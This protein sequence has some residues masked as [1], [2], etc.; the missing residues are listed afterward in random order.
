MV[1]IVMVMMHL[2]RTGM[3]LVFHVESKNGVHRR[4]AARY[5]NDRRWRFKLCFDGGAGARRGL[6]V[7]KVGLRKDNQ[8]RGANLI[9]E[10][11][12]NRTFMVKL[13]VSRTLRF[14]R[15]K[16]M[17]HA[18]IGERRPV[19]QRHDAVQHHL[20]LDIRPVERLNKRL[21]QR[22]AGCL[23]DDM[24]R[25]RLLCQQLLHAWQEII[26]DGAADASIGK[27]DDVIRAAAFGTTILEHRAIHANIAE[28]VDN[29]GQTLAV[30]LRDDVADQRG[31][32]GP[33]EPG[34]HGGGDARLCHGADLSKLGGVERPVEQKGAE[35]CDPAPKTDCRPA[36]QRC[37]YMAEKTAPSTISTI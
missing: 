5:R 13:F 33:K 20:V 2:R 26:G 11:L 18:A 31:F 14:Q 25:T 24:V 3:R 22:E 15:S 29:Q 9:R 35:P 21:R 37:H 36:G 28:F 16:V 6:L 4:G 32:T 1:M 17:R 10:Q 19:D 30:G 23:D 27:L 12:V 7:Q 34:D 8:I